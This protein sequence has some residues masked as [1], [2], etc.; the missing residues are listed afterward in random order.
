M[1][2]RRERAVARKKTAAA[3]I[4]HA[5]LTQQRISN[6]RERAGEDEREEERGMVAQRGFLARRTKTT[7]DARNFFETFFF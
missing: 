2:R 1:A 3:D 7:R 5:R 4:W 6:A